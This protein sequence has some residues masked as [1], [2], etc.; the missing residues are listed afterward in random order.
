MQL[1]IYRIHYFGV[2]MR[3]VH[4]L[5]ALWYKDFSLGNMNSFFVM[6]TFV[7]VYTYSRGFPV[8]LITM[9]SCC[10]P[11]GYS[12]KQVASNTNAAS[13]TLTLPVA[14]RQFLRYIL[15]TAASLSILSVFVQA[16]ILYAVPY[17]SIPALSFFAKAIPSS[18]H[19]KNATF[20]T[21]EFITFTITN[22][23]FY[24]FYFSH[25]TNNQALTKHFFISCLP[26]VVVSSVL[27][28]LINKATSPLCT[29]LQATDYANQLRQ[30]PFLV[31]SFGIWVLTWFVIYKTNVKKF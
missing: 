23:L 10:I 7:F 26:S 20:F 2:S 27:V 8:Y 19:G 16:I 5:I 4:Q 28:S 11:T 14:R 18:I 3:K 29:M 1:R 9:V 24:P 17:K 6:V 22:L 13:H 31:A 12:L 25:V 15:L 30:L 21:I